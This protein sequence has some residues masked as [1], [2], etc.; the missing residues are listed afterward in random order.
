[1]CCGFFLPLQI[2]CCVQLSFILIDNEFNE[3]MFSFIVDG[4]RRHFAPFLS[5]T[6]VK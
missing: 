4:M 5:T 6:Q 1:M 3:T 2:S